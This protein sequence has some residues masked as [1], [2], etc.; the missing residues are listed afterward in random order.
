MNILDKIRKMFSRGEMPEEAR[1]VIRDAKTTQEALA[2]LDSVLT[3]NEIEI[4]K[5]KKE[6]D[7]VDGILQEEEGKVRDE[8]VLGRQKR[9]TLQYVKR[10]RGHLDNLENRMSIFDK[11]INLH[12]KLIGKIQDMEAMALRGVDEAQIDR[13]IMEFEDHVSKYMDVVHAGEAGFEAST[14]ITDRE[15]RDLARL[16]REILGLEDAKKENEDEDA[17][18]EPKAK[19]PEREAPR[20]ERAAPAKAP[21]RVDEEQDEEEEEDEDKRMLE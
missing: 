13:I 7:K 8:K 21:A 2:G 20:K 16:E 15:D 3:R 18:P 9:Y 5:L 6:I 19:E 4:N 17:Q 12:I 11:N 1:S 14:T 10:L